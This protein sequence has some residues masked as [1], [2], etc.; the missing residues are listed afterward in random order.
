MKII[1]I[2]GGIGAGKSTVLSILEQEYGAYCVEADKVAHKLMEPGEA[3]YQQI[4]EVFSPEVLDQQKQIHRGRM[5]AL[6]FQHP[7]KREQLNRIVHP[8]VKQYIRND[9][10]RCRMEGKAAI[11]VL[12]AALL[13]EDGYKQICDEL[14]YVY[15]EEEQRIKRLMESRGYSREKCIQIL[16]S[17][18]TEDFYRGNCDRIIQNDGDFEN[19]KKQVEQFLMYQ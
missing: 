5:S 16:N 15:A 11:Y 4:I 19:T 13:I 6:I 1:G 2:T 18:S 7:E 17:Q 14:W 12:E 10:E 9:I 3:V 8:A